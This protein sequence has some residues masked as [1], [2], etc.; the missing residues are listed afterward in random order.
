MMTLSAEQQAMVA[1]FQ[2]HVEAELAGDTPPTTT[3]YGT[4]DRL[5]RISK[6]S[7]PTM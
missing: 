7:I 4:S 3:G 6:S 2:R 5:T 1:L